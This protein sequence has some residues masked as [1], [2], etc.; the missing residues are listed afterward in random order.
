MAGIPYLGL[1]TPL[2]ADFRSLVP[3]CLSEG[4]LEGG[5]LTPVTVTVLLDYSA[6][7]F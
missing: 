3:V 2:K 7:E 5:S 4:E 1:S 6:D